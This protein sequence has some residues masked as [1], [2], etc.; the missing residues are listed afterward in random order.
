MTSC[1][2]IL[3]PGFPTLEFQQNKPSLLQLLLSGN[4]IIAK[5]KI[6]KTPHESEDLSSD[7]HH[8]HKTKTHRPGMLVEAFNLCTWEAEVGGSCKFQDSH[9]VE[10][11]SLKTNNKNKNKN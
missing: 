7:P 6:T 5:G 2:Q 11:L 9:I 1:F 10:M 4:V 3:L 8:P